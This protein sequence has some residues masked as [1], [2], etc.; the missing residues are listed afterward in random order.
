M[1]AKLMGRVWDLDLPHPHQSILLALADHADH[2]GHNVYPS[3][4]LIA[5]KSGYSPR[6]TKRIMLELVERG[7]LIKVREAHAARPTEYRIDLSAGELKPPYD[8]SEHTEAK[9]GYLR[10][11]KMT[12]QTG[13]QDDPPNLFDMSPQGVPSATVG[14]D[15][16][17]TPEPSIEPSEEPPDPPLAPPED[18]GG[19]SEESAQQRFMQSFREPREGWERTANGRGRRQRASRRGG[20]PV[21]VPA[22][23]P[24]DPE[25]VASLNGDAGAAQAEWDRV[26]DVVRQSVDAPV[27]AIWL[28]PLTVAGRG[29]DGALVLTGETAQVGWAI[30]RFG[31]LLDAAAESV[32]VKVRIARHGATVSEV[33][34][35]GAG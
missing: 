12:P 22:A 2:E 26:L 34:P 14:G 18:G 21:P 16:A 20:K 9:H 1:S 35:P 28:D 33:R 4:G 23:P 17:V 24:P 19:G 15:I 6:Q 32:G 27:V 8:S 25:P 11:A 5:W 30:E 13:C 31:R 10:G 3:I 29:Q 7:L